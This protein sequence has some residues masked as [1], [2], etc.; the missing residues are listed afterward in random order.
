[1]FGEAEVLVAAKDLVNDR[2]VRRIVG[3]DVDYIH[4][5]FD[6]HQIVMSEG[7]ATESFHPGPQTMADLPD[8]ALRELTTL[9]PDLDPATGQGFGPAARRSLKTFEARAL[10][11]AARPAAQGRAA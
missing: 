9:F 2:S 1:M 8:E 11:G 3:G 7:L 10:V 5:L 4:L 6:R